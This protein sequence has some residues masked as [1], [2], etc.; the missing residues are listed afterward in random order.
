ME[1]SD[2]FFAILYGSAF[3]FIIHFIIGL[4]HK[5]LAETII[6]YDQPPV[7]QN[8]VL[9]PFAGSYNHWPYWTGG[10][11]RG[12]DGGYGRGYHRF[13][14][15]YGGAGRGAHPGMGRGGFGSRGARHI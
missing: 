11:N 14:R 2:I 3:I 4:L 9:N 15:P 12:S 5:P 6:V 7:Y 10:Y 1:L 8:T 13:G